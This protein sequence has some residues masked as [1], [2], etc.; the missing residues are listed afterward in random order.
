[1]STPEI[2][3]T[4]PV[5]LCAADGRHLNPA[6]LG[7]SRRPL[8]RVNLAGGWGR[9]KRW[10]YWAIQAEDV[11]IAVTIADLD[12]LGLV[13]VGWIDLAS[14]RS[15][16]R[17]VARPLA[18]GIELPDTPCAGRL[19]YQSRDLSVSV[20][21]EPSTSAVIRARWTER[22]GAE[23][24]LDL[25][26][27]PPPGG[28]SLNV[29]IPWSETR[30]QYTS[31]HQGRAVSGSAEF[32]GRSFELG[33]EGLEAWGILDVGRGRWPYRTRWN[34]GGGAGTSI[35]GPVVA[36]Q[37][38]A[39]WTEDTGFTEN[40]IFIDGRLTK[41]G[42]E[43]RWDYSWHDPLGPWRVRSADDA[44]DVTLFPTHDRHDRINAIAVR[45]EVHQ[46][47]G[48]WAGTVPDGEDGTL[49]V[50]RIQGFAE[51]SRSR[52]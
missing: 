21:Y 51:E 46:V 37:F 52:W 14:H 43:L 1:M 34:W 2:E 39:K 19:S 25:T 40:G 8:H 41:I 38:G 36:L 42:E 12:Y 27:A 28:E 31:K 23:G 50:D 47:F 16:G 20:S 18:R 44:L 4:A 30:F 11:V 45:T 33:G 7:W 10:D 3:L 26:V 48:R 49:T 24:Q 15:G 13:T 35:D 22:G 9:T 29:V 32:D 6:A 17:S 5:D